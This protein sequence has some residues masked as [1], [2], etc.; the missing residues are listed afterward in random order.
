MPGGATKSVSELGAKF[1]GLCSQVGSAQPILAEVAAAFGEHVALGVIGDFG[2]LTE[3]RADTVL[4]VGAAIAVRSARLPTVFAVGDRYPLDKTA[5]GRVLSAHRE[6]LGKFGVQIRK[7][8][9]VVVNGT[10]DPEVRSIAVPVFDRSHDVIAA[11]SIACLATR[12]SLM[13]IRRQFLPRLL[14]ASAELSA[15]T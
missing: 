15:L 1:E 14:V 5:L 7:N 13:E 6:G 8:G 9:F 3:G 12:A 11:L 2:G 4:I 10:Y